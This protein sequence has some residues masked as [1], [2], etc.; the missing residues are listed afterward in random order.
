MFTYQ[1]KKL[2]SEVNFH[3][4]LTVVKDL[5]GMDIEAVKKLIIDRG[6]PDTRVNS[7]ITAWRLTNVNQ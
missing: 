6:Y 1:L 7:I 2:Y 5:K 4:D 3:W